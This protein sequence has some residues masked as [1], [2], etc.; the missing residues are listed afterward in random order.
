MFDIDGDIVMLTLDDSELDPD[1]LNEIVTEVV[2]FIESDV[3]ND[4]R[5]ESVCDGLDVGLGELERDVV[6]DTER[7]GVATRVL[8]RDP[9]G[10]FVVD[11]DTEAETVG[12]GGG[13]IVSVT[14]RESVKDNDADND[15]DGRLFERL[16]V[17]VRV[18]AGVFVRDFDELSERVQVGVGGGVTL[19]DIL[20]E[21]V[22][23][24]EG[25]GGGVSVL[26][27]VCDKVALQDGV[28]GG[29]QVDE[30]DV[31][32]VAE[33]DGVGGGVRVPVMEPELDAVSEGVAM[34]VGVGVGSNDNEFVGW[35][36]GDAV[37]DKDWIGVGVCLV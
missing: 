36:E 30:T 28:G 10:L 34:C 11:A 21:R 37:S 16:G 14:L 33:R 19:G 31:V 18:G 13:V 3:D 1:E 27:N 32:Q 23:V 15:R 2:A 8:L 17:V 29:V 35:L 20:F 25:V 26:D 4:T 7:L 22:T 5:M 9:V 12:V 24:W 6:K